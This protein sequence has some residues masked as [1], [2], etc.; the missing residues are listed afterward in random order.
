MENEVLKTYIFFS[1]VLQVPGT[2]PSDL[3][4]G[5]GVRTYS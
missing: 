5:D 3:N 4:P 1:D 2:E